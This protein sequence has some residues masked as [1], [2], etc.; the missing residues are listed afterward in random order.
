MSSNFFLRNVSRSAHGIHFLDK[1]YELYRDR[2]LEL[3][4]IRYQDIE[5]YIDQNYNPLRLPGVEA[6]K[7]GGSQASD[8]TGIEGAQE[9][10]DSYSQDCEC[11]PGDD[12]QSDPQE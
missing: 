8:L 6:D 7:S 3:W 10:C 1:S 12:L 9:E 11:E 2:C 4:G 5:V